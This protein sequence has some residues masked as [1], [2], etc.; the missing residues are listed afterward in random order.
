MAC[1]T[2]GEAVVFDA[3]QSLTNDPLM[4]KFKAITWSAADPAPTADNK[5]DALLDAINTASISSA[6]A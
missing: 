4:R 3:S 6:Y 2:S 5:L 1:S